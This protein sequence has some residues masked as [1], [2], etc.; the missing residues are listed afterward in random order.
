[1]GPKQIH[2]EAGHRPGHL[3]SS[4]LV[5][6][7]FEFLVMSGKRLSAF[8]QLRLFQ[9]RASFSVDAINRLEIDLKSNLVG[10]LDMSE[11]TLSIGGSL[12]SA[13]NSNCVDQ[14]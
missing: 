12:S 3:H 11:Q 13:P 8:A 4:D 1:M 14:Q 2:L 10:E 5:A 9:L 7:C 6:T